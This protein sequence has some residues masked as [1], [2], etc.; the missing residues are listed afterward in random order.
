MKLKDSGKEHQVGNPR[1]PACDQ[2]GPD[3]G[4]LIPSVRH[5]PYSDTSGNTPCGGLV[6]SEVFGD[7]SA[8]WEP[9]Y[10]CDKCGALH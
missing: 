4:H 7:G 2:Q 6:H 3:G 10:Q 1:C 5:F 8:G 9:L